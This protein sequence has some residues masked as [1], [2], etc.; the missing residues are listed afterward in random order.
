MKHINNRNFLKWLCFCV[1]NGAALISIS[2]NNS[3]IA[4]GFLIS[5][6]HIIF[7]HFEVREKCS[8]T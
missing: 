2:H 7:A 1:I 6:S 5:V 8:K 3:Y 4:A